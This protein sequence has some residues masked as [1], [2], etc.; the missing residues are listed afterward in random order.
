MNLSPIIL[1]VYNRPE[2]TKKTVDALK[3]NQLASES[4][5]FIFSD[6]YK[7]E[8]DRKKVEEVRN[9][10]T[11]ISGFKEIKITLREKNLGLAD[12]VISGV[13]EI[14]NEY[15]KVIVLEDDIVTSP[16]FLKFMNEAL[17]FYEDD[18]RI[19]SISGYNFPIKIPES[20]PH[21]IYISPRPSSWGWATW[22]DRWL[23]SEWL[24]EKVF[25]IKN[26]ELLHNLMDKAGED[27]APMLL[28]AVE[29]KINSW[30]IKWAF[31][32]LIKNA[33]C[34]YPIKSL[35]QNAGADASGTNFT[36]ITRK[37]EVEPDVSF[38][39]FVFTKDLILQKE[40]NDQIKMIV[41]PG[42]LSYIKYRFFNLY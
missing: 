26:R 21:Q 2:H 31:T 40:I 32:H 10:I 18:K 17:D 11:T 6:G 36:K 20:Y 22:K 30:A 34:V 9:Y 5:L 3:L 37:Y 13:T 12:S 14:I 8:T 42:L 7:N 25:D 19:Y 28:K 23:T 1:F 27:L 4:L 16:Y 35:V 41:K 39:E 15:G 38:R 29:N 24:P 33:F